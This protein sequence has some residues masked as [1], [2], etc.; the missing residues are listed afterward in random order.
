MLSRDDI[1]RVAESQGYRADFADRVGKGT[2]RAR[3]EVCARTGHGKTR[4]TKYL[5][6]LKKIEAISEEALIE[7]IAWKFKEVATPNAGNSKDSSE[8]S[9]GRVRQP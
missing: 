2:G 8:K 3:V 1:R 5:G 7:L 4:I 9:K 6:N